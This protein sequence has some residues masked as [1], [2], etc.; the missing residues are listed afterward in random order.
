MIIFFT[1]SFYIFDKTVYNFLKKYK[2]S[3]IIQ[4]AIVIFATKVTFFD[5]LIL[6]HKSET[7]IVIYSNF[8]LYGF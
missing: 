7:Y 1:F 3:Y 8:K 4:G 6:N 2:L 5:E